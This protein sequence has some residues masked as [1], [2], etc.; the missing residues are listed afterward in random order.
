[1]HNIFY[2]ICHII[3]TILR[4]ILSINPNHDFIVITASLVISIFAFLIPLS[5]SIISKVS[6][7]YSSD[8]ISNLFKRKGVIKIA[9]Y[10]LFFDICLI[11]LLQFL[12]KSIPILYLKLIDWLILIISLII[13]Y[14]T[15]KIINEIVKFISDTGY[16]IN[17]L[18]KN[19]EEIIEK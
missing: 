5:I 17:E 12:E 15:I 1:M 9:E 11:I 4:I 14:I 2:F 10:S 6:E 16:V 13:V 8:V 7:R 3:R 19:I 18:A